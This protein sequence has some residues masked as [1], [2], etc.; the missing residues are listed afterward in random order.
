MPWVESL[1]EL[2]WSAYKA[3]P[4]HE[5]LRREFE[6][7]TVAT[8]DRKSPYLWR[9]VGQKPANGWGLVIAMHGGGNAPA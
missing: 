7:K 2:A 3:S 9:Y 5:P 8:K 4:T 6:A 1:R